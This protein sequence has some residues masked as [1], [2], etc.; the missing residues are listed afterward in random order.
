M[1]AVAAA[2]AVCPQV[3]NCRIRAEE[4]Q[5]YVLC[6]RGIKPFITISQNQLRMGAKGVMGRFSTTSLP[7]SSLPGNSV[8]C[9]T[10]SHTN[11]DCALSALGQEEIGRGCWDKAAV[12]FI[13]LE[14]V[15]HFSV[16]DLFS[17]FV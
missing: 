17:V 12:V 4:P 8:P 11:M 7:L 15:L 16:L 2:V 1:G 9:C 14:E 5:V 13:V 6:R 3:V 10:N